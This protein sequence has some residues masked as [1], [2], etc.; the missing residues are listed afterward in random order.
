LTGINKPGYR[1]PQA[2]STSKSMQGTVWALKSLLYAS[3]NSVGGGKGTVMV[4]ANGQQVATFAIA[5]DNSDV[6][7]Q[8]DLREQLKP[9][10]NDITLNYRGDGSFLYQIVGRYYV[11]WNLVGA[12]PIRS[13]QPLSLSVAYDK[14][15]LAQDDTV[16]VTVT[17]HNN[18]RRIAEMPLVDVGVPPGFTAVPDRLDA[19]VERRTISKYAVAARQVIVYLEKL[20]PAQ[21]VT[22]TYQLRAKYPI[23]A[24]TPQSRAYACYDPTRVVT[25]APQMIVVHR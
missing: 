3:T 2:Y 7:R 1:E 8:I 12:Q 9:G 19:A 17:I 25:S 5:P 16:T 11:P 22:L 14:T 18:T 10:K 15:T 21:T 4:M 6:M 24:R 23:K 13:P 20:N